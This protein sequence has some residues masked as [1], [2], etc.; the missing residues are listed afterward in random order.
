MGDGPNLVVCRTPSH[1]AA[2][3]GA[4]QRRVANRRRGK[5]NA[6]VNRQPVF[7]SALHQSVFDH[8]GRGLLRETQTGSEQGK[9]GSYK[10]VFFHKNHCCIFRHRPGLI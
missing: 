1:F 10:T 4:R 3:W 9:N 2:G 5:R 8:D 6:P 7:E